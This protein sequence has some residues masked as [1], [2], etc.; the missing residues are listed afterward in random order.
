MYTCPIY[1]IIVPLQCRQVH[2]Y[3]K[4]EFLYYSVFTMIS[5]VYIFICY[6]FWH[7]RTHKLHWRTHQ[8]QVR[9]L[10]S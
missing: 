6:P 7:W 1:T 8:L 10:A 2:L 4:T 5:A 9:S 3:V